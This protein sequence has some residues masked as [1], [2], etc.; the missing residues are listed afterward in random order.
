MADCLSVGGFVH[1]VWCPVVFPHTCPSLLLAKPGLSAQ[2]QLWTLVLLL[3]LQLVYNA[4]SLAPSVSGWS[5]GVSSLISAGFLP[6]FQVQLTGMFAFA[7]I[8][9]FFFLPLPPS[10]HP[11]LPAS[12][13]S[14]F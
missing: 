14:F 2:P 9:D 1:L 7:Q 3:T 10:L 8:L 5:V 11:C 6:D 12:F 4:G 13:P